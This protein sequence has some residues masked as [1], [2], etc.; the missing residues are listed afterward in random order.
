M[1]PAR[2]TERA[3]Q[4]INYAHEE[5][6]KLNHSQV[7]TEHL[8]LGLIHEG[9]RD[10]QGIAVSALQDLGV[11]LDSLE[12]EVKKM[13]KKSRVLSDNTRRQ[14]FFAHAANQ[15]LQ[16][17]M[18]E[19]QRL[20]YDHVGTEHIL[21]GLIRE[22]NGIAA[23]VL[24]NFSVTLEK[25]RRIVKPGGA[26]T[27]EDDTFEGLLRTLGRDKAEVTIFFDREHQCHGTIHRVGQDFITLRRENT[28]V[29]IPITALRYIETRKIVEKQ[30]P[31]SQL[32]ASV[33]PAKDAV[34]SPGEVLIDIEPAS[35]TDLREYDIDPYVAQIL[36]EEVVRQLNMLPLK[37]EDDILY[38]AATEPLNL[39]GIDELKLLTGLKVKP[40]IVSVQELRQA[41][42]G[43]FSAGQKS[44]QCIIDMT[45]Q[46]MEILSRR[47]NQVTMPELEE[48]PV[49][50]LV[51][52][53]IHIAV[54][55]NANEIR[56][57]PQYPEMCVRY[58]LDGGLRDITCIPRHIESAVVARIKLLAGMDISERQRPQHGYIGLTSKGQ[59][60]GLNVST[61]F[62]TDGEGVM[63]E[64]LYE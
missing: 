4:I 6:I 64:I 58:R 14:L 27:R 38:V 49:V 12:M 53:I 45:F 39:P 55:D 11:S 22:K 1:V 25:V 35:V 32:S 57:E 62:T 21:L 36:P 63:I 19:A 8:L 40:V 33:T 26:I 41:I 17:S 34:Q 13:I 44:K 59:H 31:T 43:H 30:N 56:L 60:I 5:A 23:R 9:L 61:I 37:I 42:N 51:N 10:G 3:R 24:A 28:E 7:D 16:F 29:V 20:G 52:S 15:V 2:F 50:E 48:A 46:E 47:G 54:N 18:E